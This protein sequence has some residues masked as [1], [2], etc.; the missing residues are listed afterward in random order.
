[1]LHWGFVVPLGEHM[2]KILVVGGAGYVGSAACAWLLD[3]GHDVS[4]LDDLSTGHRELA[5]GASFIQARA[6]DRSVVLPLLKRE[7]FD[8][9]MHFAAKSLVGESVQ[10]PEL[11]REN[12]IDQ[13]RLLLEMMLEAGTRRFIFS[14]TCAVFGDPGTPRISEHQPK[15][16]INP[17]GETKLEAE[18]LL[19]QMASRGL[20]SVALRYFNAA[21]AE[22]KLRVGEWHPCETHLIPRVLKAILREEAIEIYGTDYPTPDGTCIRDYVHVTDLAAAHEAALKKLM[23]LPEGA[24]RFEAYNL[25]SENGFSVRE[26]V[27]AC[28]QVTGKRALRIEK[29]R[30]PGDPPMLVGDSSLARKELGYAP[31]NTSLKT[32]I[33]SAWQWEQKLSKGFHPAIFLDRDGTINEDPGYLSDPSMVKLLPGAGEALARLKKA[34]YLLIVVSNQSGVARGLIPLEKLALIHQRMD[35]LLAP[36]G[37]KIDHYELCTHHPDEQCECRKPKP[38]LLLDSGARLGVDFSR[39][40]MVGDRDSDI[41]AGKAAGCKAAV[42]LRTNLEDKGFHLSEADF[43]ANTLTEATDW[44]LSQE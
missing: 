35:E 39:S 11:Y 22:P 19:E 23:T 4:I 9:V 33:Q 42:F 24:G 31:K 8:A 27:Q 2:P 26:V 28:E 29:P 14:S 32:I 16:P 15:N 41:G 43:S 30:R 7:R 21:G 36:F 34:G 40:Y 5:L 25:G 18:K 12:N 38:R 10:F 6:G 13:T 3:Q 20:Q 17:Y 37:A 1:M 44:I